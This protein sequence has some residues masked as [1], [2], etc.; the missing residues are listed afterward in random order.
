LRE[1]ELAL[2]IEDKKC[3]HGSAPLGL[4]KLRPVAVRKTEVG[5]GRARVLIP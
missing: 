5:G 2:V 1:R 4:N 3:Q